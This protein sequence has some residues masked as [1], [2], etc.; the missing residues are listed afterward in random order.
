[1]DEESCA[2]NTKTN[3]PRCSMDGLVAYIWATLGIHV[4]NL[5]YVITNYQLYKNPSSV[6]RPPGHIYFLFFV[7][8]AWIPSL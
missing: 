7:V 8:H 6:I 1:M 2:E 3:H 5:E 4:W